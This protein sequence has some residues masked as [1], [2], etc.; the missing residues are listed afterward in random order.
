[1]KKYEV[2]FIVRPDD[3]EAVEAVIA[4]VE[5]IITGTGGE[6]EKTDKWGKRRL[7][8]EVKK[9]TEGYYCVI[10]FAAEPKTVFE[11]ERVLKITDGVLRHMVVAKDEE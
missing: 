2:I 4:K 5:G 8:Y 3:E 1:V 9:Q 10:Y 7:A 11:L 6:I